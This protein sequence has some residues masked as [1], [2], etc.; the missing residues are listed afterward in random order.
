MRVAPLRVRGTSESPVEAEWAPLTT[1]R[2][3]PKLLRYDSGEFPAKSTGYGSWSVGLFAPE[4][5]GA[6]AC[7]VR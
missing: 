7:Q 2:I 1:V 3:D 4:G 6:A 5:K